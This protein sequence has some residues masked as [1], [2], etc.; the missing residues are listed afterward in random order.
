VTAR[1]AARQVLAALAILIAAMTLAQEAE[2][3]SGA[4]NEEGPLLYRAHCLGCHGK[5]GKGGPPMADQL[6][7]APPDPTIL[8]SRNEGRFPC[9]KIVELVDGHRHS[10]S[11]GKRTRPVWGFSFQTAGLDYGFGS[12]S[13]VDPEAHT[14]TLRSHPRGES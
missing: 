8:A 11:H 6:E 12:L 5:D 4:A 7:W 14:A 1:L 9:E 13:R 2:P 3:P 10:P